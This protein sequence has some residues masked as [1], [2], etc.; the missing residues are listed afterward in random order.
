[1]DRERII[2]LTHEYGGE[3]AINH[4]RRICHLVKLIAN[5][6]EY[7]ENVVWIAAQLHDWGGY[8][9]FARAGVAHQVRSREVAEEFLPSEGCPPDLA[10][11]VLECIEAHHGGPPDRSIESLLFTDADALDLLGVV[12]VCRVFSMWPRDLRG[13][14]QAIQTWR[15][16]STAAI[17]HPKAR[18][19]AET[20]IEETNAML[21]A[22]EEEAFGTF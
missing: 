5:G 14:W 11:R 20:R 9:Q 15:D 10:A 1:L 19:M 6:A 8:P 17:T 22:F 3:W 12:G 16:T 13:A 7:D 21:R 4:A 2:K 18:A